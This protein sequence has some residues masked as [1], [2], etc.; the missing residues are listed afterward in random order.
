MAIIHFRLPRQ[1]IRSALA[2]SVVVGL[3]VAAP[4][5]TLAAQEAERTTVSSDSDDDSTEEAHENKKR[6]KHGKG[7]SFLPIPIFV[8]EPAIGVGLGAALAYFHEKQGEEAAIPRAM[9]PQSPG[10]TAKNE[11]TTSNHYRLR[12]RLRR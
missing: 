1:I 4:A 7:P 10:K 5:R 11:E 8:T 2:A 12:R 6:K 3:F 9:T